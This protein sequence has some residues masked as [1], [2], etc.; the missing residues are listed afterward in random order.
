MKMKNTTTCTLC[1]RLSLA[2]ISGRISSIEAPVV[3]IKLAS[4][5]PIA[6]I[7]GVERRRAVQV[8]ADVD[9]AGHGEQRREQDDERDVL[10]HQ[11]MHQL[12]AGQRGAEDQRRRAAG[13]PAPRPPTPCRSGGARTRAP[14]AASARSTAGC[15]RRARPTAATGCRRRTRRRWPA[16]KQHRQRPA[17][18]RRSR[19]RTV[20]DRSEQPSGGGLRDLEHLAQVGQV[21]LVVAHVLGRACPDSL[22][23]GWS[24]QR[25][26][27][28]TICSGS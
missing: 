9:A 21:L 26:I 27:L 11:R 25:I 2:R 15:R 24:L 3:P 16:R 20:P 5:A 28:M 10:G 12:R 18:V 22:A 23:T 1:A 6:R 8:A 13:R 17:A 4:T 14:A 7:A 19:G